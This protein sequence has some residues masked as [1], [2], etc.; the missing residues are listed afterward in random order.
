MICT[1]SNLIANTFQNIALNFI[2]GSVYQMTRGGTIAT[3]FFFS[4]VY[5]KNRSKRHQI[6]GSALAVIGVIVVGVSNVIYSHGSQKTTGNVQ[7]HLCLG[8]A[9]NRIY[10][11]DHLFVSE[12]FF[13]GILRK[14]IKNISSWTDI[15]YWIR[16]NIWNK[17]ICDSPYMF[18]FRAL[19]IWNKR[20]CTL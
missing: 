19:F 17:C 4:V 10:L 13:F 9:S 14:I 6:V 16:G 7:K 20:L 18:Y 15:T 3:A 5:L 12:W 2:S 8:F 11:I 1:I